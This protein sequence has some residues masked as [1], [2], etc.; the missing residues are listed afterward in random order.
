[1]FRTITCRATVSLVA[2]FVGWAVFAIAGRTREVRAPRIQVREISAITLKRQGCTD[3]ELKCPVFDVTFRSDGT[4][5]FT[6]YAN[7]EFIGR[8][9]AHYPL[10]D[11]GV[12]AEQIERQKFFDLPVRFSADPTEETIVTE[13]VTSAGS[14]V[15]TTYNW[16]DTPSELRAIHA[17]IE[18]ELL[19]P[20]WD[21]SDNS[22]RPRP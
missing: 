3:L 9:E 8:F 7:D 2:F 21:E 15:V 17:L 22:E 11:F 13:V 19:V 20:E 10:Q 6:G 18:Y 4:A 1:M 5:A 14:H 16:R 12:L